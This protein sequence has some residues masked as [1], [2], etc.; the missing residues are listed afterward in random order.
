MLKITLRDPIPYEYRNKIIHSFQDL[1]FKYEY[2]F[3]SYPP[4]YNDYSKHRL[5]GKF[6]ALSRSPCENIQI[7]F[8]DPDEKEEFFSNLDSNI[9]IIFFCERKK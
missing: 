1:G 4:E 7:H 2:L 8:F 5:V 6:P 3:S 9:E